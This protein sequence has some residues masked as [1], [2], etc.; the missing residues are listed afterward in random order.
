MIFGQGAAGNKIY[1]GLRRFGV[2][3]SNYQTEAL[4][5]WTG[6]GTSNTYPRLVLNDPNNNFSNPSDFHLK[7][8]DYFRIKVVQLGYNLPT[9]L[10]SKAGLKKA[11]IYVMSENLFTFTKYNGYDPEIGGGTM[12]IDRGIYPQARSFLVG[13]NIGF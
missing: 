10:I 7:K 12:S 3:G 5:R 1:Q 6:E 11:R 2:T 13:A 8:G 9:D 4:S